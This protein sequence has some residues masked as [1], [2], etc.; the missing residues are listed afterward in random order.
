MRRK[1]LYYHWET[2]YGINDEVV[3]PPSQ[4]VAQVL[5]RDDVTAARGSAKEAGSGRD[6]RNRRS[7]SS[8]EE[9]TPDCW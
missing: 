8:G 1:S 6:E 5:W 4:Q 9:N 7:E 3:A 2:V